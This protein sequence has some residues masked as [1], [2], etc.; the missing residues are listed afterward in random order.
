M[1]TFEKRGKFW[2][3]RI[4]RAGAPPQTRSFDDRAQ[5][6]KWARSIESEVDAG[7]LIDR[8]AAQRTSLAEILERYRRE[9]TPTKRGARDESVRIKAM[10]SRPFAQIRISSLTSA[11]LAA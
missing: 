4:R 11:Y 3:V 10:A 2:R 9:V 5:A 8:R 7:I 6:Q 1:A